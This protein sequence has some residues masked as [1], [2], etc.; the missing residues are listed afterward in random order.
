MP[1]VR[2]LHSSGFTGKEGS[3]FLHGGWGWGKKAG[4]EGEVQQRRIQPAAPTTQGPR[5][6]GSEANRGPQ[7]SPQNR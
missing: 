4:R 2:V 3:G 5:S 6:W 7:R 1:G